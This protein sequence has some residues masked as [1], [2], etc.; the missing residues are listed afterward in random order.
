[1]ISFSR[2]ESVPGRIVCA[3][4]TV[5]H[6]VGDLECLAVLPLLELALHGLHLA[7]HLHAFK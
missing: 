1:M 4:F 5:P 6:L 7:P 2:P 3:F